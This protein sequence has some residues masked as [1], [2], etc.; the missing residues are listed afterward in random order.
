MADVLVR[1]L[2]LISEPGQQGLGS[3][4]Q[5]CGSSASGCWEHCPSLASQSILMLNRQVVETRW[6]RGHNVGGGWFWHCRIPVLILGYS[7]SVQIKLN[8]RCTNF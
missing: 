3:L 8:Q 2:N 6:G 1:N 5:P 4:L 7:F